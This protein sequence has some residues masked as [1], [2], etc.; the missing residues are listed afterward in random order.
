MPEIGLHTCLRRLGA[1]AFQRRTAHVRVRVLCARRRARLHA[2][3][4]AG[5]GSAR[6]RV[7]DAAGYLRRRS[8]SASPTACS[9]RGYRRAGTQKND[10]LCESFPT[11]R[12]TCQTHVDTHVY[13]HVYTR[14]YT[15]VHTQVYT[16]VCKHMSVR[17]SAHVSARRQRRGLSVS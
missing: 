6:R 9:L 8:I 15:H 4:R 1:R 17:T 14:V 11:V 3:L 13:T 10:R 12:S 7:G 5:E 16:R 2:R